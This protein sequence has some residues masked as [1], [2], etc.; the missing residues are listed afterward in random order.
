MAGP[1]EDSWFL[2]LKDEVSQAVVKPVGAEGYSSDSLY[3]PRVQE[4]DPWW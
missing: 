4:D 3:D 1:L 2:E